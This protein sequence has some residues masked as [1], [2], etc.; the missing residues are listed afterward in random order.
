MQTLTSA[1]SLCFVNLAVQF[2]LFLVAI[3]N[4]ALTR[5]I[6]CIWKGNGLLFSR[7]LQ[8][9][10]RIRFWRATHIAGWWDSCLLF[11]QVYPWYETSMNTISALILMIAFPGSTGSAVL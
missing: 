1:R 6:V 10:A 4:V 11:S 5:R 7:G 2:I 3:R 8:R 9:K